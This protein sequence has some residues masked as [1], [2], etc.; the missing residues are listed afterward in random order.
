MR[1]LTILF[2]LTISFSAC[3][4]KIVEN[5]KKTHLKSYR[6]VY[7]E[8][9]KIEVYRGTYSYDENH[10]LLSE[11]Q[12]DTT[13]LLNSNQIIPVKTTI[14]YEYNQEGFL[15]KT[16]RDAL[17]I[18]LTATSITTYDYENG[19]LSR[20]DLGNRLKEYLY[21][22]NDKLTSTILTSF[23][24]GNKTVIQFEDNIPKDL[25]KTSLGY[26]FENGNEKTFLDDN[27]LVTR[28]EKYKEDLLIF[29]QDFQQ[30][31]TGLPQLLLPNF[32]GWPKIKAFE[33]Q[34]G[35]EK[36]IITYQ[37]IDGKKTLSDR[38]VLNNTFDAKGNL[39][40]NEGFEEINKETTKPLSRTLLFEYAYEEY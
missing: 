3:E 32:K 4:K 25:V 39:V 7:T 37:Y 40:K 12:N 19:L 36:E 13:Y 38:K 34:K 16:T 29:E 24:T 6:T 35:V 28:F 11:N 31:K 14:T 2:L 10:R 8:P 30:S 21:G 18:R 27:L 1:K 26:H 5:E 23:V 22:A 20:E 15:T 33:Y 17:S 9:D